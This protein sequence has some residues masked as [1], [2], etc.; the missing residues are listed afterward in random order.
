MD[1]PAS[2]TVISGVDLRARGVND[3]A[4]ALSLAGG[5]SIAPGGDGGPASSVPELMGLR[6]FD[7]YLLVVDGVPWSG[8]FNP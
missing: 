5:V 6:E 7:A 4:G 1:V 2:V 8:A 3:L